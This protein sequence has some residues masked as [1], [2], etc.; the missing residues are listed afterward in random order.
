M[1]ELDRA[2]LHAKPDQLARAVAE[3]TGELPG[4]API[5]VLGGRLLYRRA[6]ASSQFASRITLV[7]DAYHA[8]TTDRPY[9]AALT[10]AEARTELE[11]ECGRQFCPHA[12]RALLQILDG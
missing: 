7:C 11:L 2:E 4:E 8:M 1:L 5:G 12:T 10:N 9:R 6:F 3:R